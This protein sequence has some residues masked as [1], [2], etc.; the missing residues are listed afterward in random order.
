MSKNKKNL[1]KKTR[2]ANAEQHLQMS[3]KL[4]TSIT[5]QSA[6]KRNLN[7]FQ[8]SNKYSVYQSSICYEAWP[9]SSNRNRNK[10]YCLR[11]PTDKGQPQQFSRESK[12][13]PSP[14]PP[15]LRGL[16]Q[17]EEMLIARALPLFVFI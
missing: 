8:K 1:Q 13:V 6:N 10:C 5:E 14:V 2:Q 12:M 9:L 7:A 15:E 4:D 16:T 11:C 17:I 3:N